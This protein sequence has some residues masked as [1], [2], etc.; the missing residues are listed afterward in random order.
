MRDFF[1]F[2]VWILILY[3]KW[4]NYRARKASEKASRFIA[5]MLAKDPTNPEHLAM[6]KQVRALIGQGRTN[7]AAT[8]ILMD[9]LKDS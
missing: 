6:Q 7:T 5:D 1:K 4:T 9:D 2:H 3:A 8:N